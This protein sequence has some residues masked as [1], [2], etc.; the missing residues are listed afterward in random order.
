MQ[1]NV[2][3]AGGYHEEHPVILSLWQ[4]RLTALLSFSESMR[5]L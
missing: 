5:S 4:V 1:A 3:Y 2:E